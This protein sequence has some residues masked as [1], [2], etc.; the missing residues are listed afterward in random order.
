[1]TQ[2][3][4]RCRQGTSKGRGKVLRLSSGIL[5]GD[6]H[7][8]CFAEAEAALMPTSADLSSDYFDPLPGSWSMLFDA[9]HE[10]ISGPERT[11]AIVRLYEAVKYLVDAC[12]DDNAIQLAARRG[13]RLVGDADDSNSAV[14]MMR[15]AALIE[16]MQETHK[17]KG[18]V[19]AYRR[20]QKALRVLGIDNDHAINLA[21]YTLEYHDREGKPY[22]WL[23]RKLETK[24][25]K[26]R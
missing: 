18:S 6:Y 9:V 26:R 16:L 2:L 5:S 21:M 14:Q 7:A 3:C 22:E 12:P 25:A 24:G 1:M 15:V 13:G 10:H 19:A 8:G 11:K 23:A 20:I 17:Q 4:E